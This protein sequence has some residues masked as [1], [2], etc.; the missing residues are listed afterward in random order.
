VVNDVLHRAANFN[1][2]LKYQAWSETLNE[3]GFGSWVDFQNECKA[4]V[5][6]W[7]CNLGDSAGGTND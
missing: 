4:L 2:V 3:C 7:T 5:R 1:N 6:S